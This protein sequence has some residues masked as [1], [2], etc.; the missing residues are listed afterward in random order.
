MRLVIQRVLEAAC[1]VDGVTTGQIGQGYCIFAG[2]CD[3]DT[4]LVLEKM[5]RK[6]IGL[7]VFS[8]EQG[9][10]NLSIEQVHGSVLSV[11]QFTLY[12]S[13]R[14]G[15]RPSFVNAARPEVSEPL[16]EQFNELLARSVPV[17]KGI[18]G[19]DMKI[20]LINDGPV[21]IWMDSEEMFGK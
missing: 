13:C 14:K 18:F 17:E 3:T 7:R 4:P 20:D 21:T 2:F 10:M 9:L 6:V 1:R 15:N 12:A 16:Y 11:S 8:D 5:A 19:A